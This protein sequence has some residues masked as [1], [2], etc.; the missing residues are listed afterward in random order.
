[1][2]LEGRG[3]SIVKQATEL[4]VAERGHLQKNLKRRCITMVSPGGTI[5]AGLFVGGWRS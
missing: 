1:M 3:R 5:E 2:S 4:G